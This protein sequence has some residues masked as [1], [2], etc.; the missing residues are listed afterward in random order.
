[1][2]NSHAA[3]VEAFVRDLMKAQAAYT[4]AKTRGC[5]AEVLKILGDHMDKAEDAVKRVIAEAK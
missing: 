3:R 2:S 4:E 5:G 1:M